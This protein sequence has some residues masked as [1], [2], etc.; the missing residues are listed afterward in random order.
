MPYNDTQWCCRSAGPDVIDSLGAY[1]RIALSATLSLSTAT[2][3]TAFANSLAFVLA[4]SHKC[5][6]MRHA[7]GGT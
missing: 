3:P 7:V 6:V 5:E 2:V 1:N 4:A